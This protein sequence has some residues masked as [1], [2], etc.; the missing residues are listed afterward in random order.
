MT[1]LL[2]SPVTRNFRSTRGGREPA[3]NN[4]RTKP[5]RRKSE[6]WAGKGLDQFN[7]T[8][9]GVSKIVRELGFAGV[10]RR[11]T[12]WPVQGR[13]EVLK[14]SKSREDVYKEV[15]ET[16]GLVPQWVEQ[17]PDGALEGFWGMTTGF[18]LAETKIPNK[19][20]ELIGVAI[21]GATRC[22]YCA[23]F[24]T[25][26]ARLF[27]ATDEEVAEASMMGALSMMGST[28]INA[29]QI[30]YNKFVEET[31]AIVA[32]VKKNM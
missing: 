3:L 12:T 2:S 13:R 22:K 5:M 1:R 23:L 7:L 20:K 29:Q 6:I 14:M 8:R 26:A 19:Y 15:K 11:R 17:M 21:S 30:D 28:F 16:L 27:G 9:A 32:H 10:L 4:A 25:E 24:H 18:W 31:K